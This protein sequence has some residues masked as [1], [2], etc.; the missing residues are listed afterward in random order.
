MWQKLSNIFYKWIIL[1]LSDLYH[2]QIDEIPVIVGVCQRLH[3]AEL[4]HKYLG[5]H[6]LQDGL[7]NGQLCMGWLSCI[8]SQGTYT[9]V[10][11]EE[12]TDHRCHGLG[13]LLQQLLRTG[14]F[15]DDRLG[16]C[17]IV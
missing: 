9:K 15:G 4:V 13:K 14:E 1:K 11:V 7:N 8:L 2:E 5:T 6:G 10:G 3:L 12:W 17:F 16:D